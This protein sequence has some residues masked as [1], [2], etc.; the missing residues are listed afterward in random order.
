MHIQV[1]VNTYWHV[2]SVCIV[3]LCWILAKKKDAGEWIVS[4]IFAPIVAPYFVMCLLGLCVGK[5]RE[6]KLKAKE[7]T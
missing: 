2:I 5:M 6:R 4:L 7:A 1:S 3:L